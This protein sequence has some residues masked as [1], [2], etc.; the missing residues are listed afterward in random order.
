VVSSLGKRE[1]KLVLM[2][3]DWMVVLMAAKMEEM[4]VAMV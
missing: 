4:T 1:M 3:V 2:T